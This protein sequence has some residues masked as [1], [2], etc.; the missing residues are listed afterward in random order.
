[1]LGFVELVENEENAKKEIAYFNFDG[2]NPR[3]EIAYVDF[4]TIASDLPEELLSVTELAYLASRSSAPQQVHISTTPGADESGGSTW[5][6]PHHVRA[7]Q[8]EA[9]SRPKSSATRRVPLWVRLKN[10]PM[11]RPTLRVEE[12]QPT[13]PQDPVAFWQLETMT[14]AGHNDESQ[15]PPLPVQVLTHE[16]LHGAEQSIFAPLRSPP[17]AAWSRLWPK[18]QDMLQSRVPSR[19]PD[20]DKWVANVAQCE[21]LTRIPPKLRR[22]WPEKI[23]IWLD[24]SAR[25]VPFWSDQV[26]VYA[27]LYRL[28]SREGIDSRVLDTYAQTMSLQQ[29]GD[30]LADARVDVDAPLLVLGDLGIFGPNAVRA[31]WLSTGKQLLRAGV[32]LS[33]LV[34]S[35][36]ARWSPFMVS[37]W[38]AVP[39]EQGRQRGAI[40]LRPDAKKWTE[41]TEQLLKL[42]SPAAYLQPEM[43]RVIRLLLPPGM[44][45]A[46]T[47]ADVWN[48]VDV[49]IADHAGLILY[50]DRAAKWR[51]KFATDTAVALKEGVG[52]VLR[53]WHKRL[54]QELLRVETLAWYATEPDVPPPGDLDDAVA[55][56]TRLD[57][58]LRSPVN[59]PI[60]ATAVKRYCRALLAQ[61]PES[62][63][64]EL[65]ALK[66]IRA[67]LSPS[68]ELNR[69]DS[70]SPGATLG[71]GQKVQH[72][73]VRQIGR[74]LEFSLSDRGTAWPSHIK[75][76]GSP[77]AWLMA[78]NPSIE[79]THP[80]TKTTK[81][82][83]YDGLS[84]PIVHDEPLQLQTD[85]CTAT[86][87]PWYRESWVTA[88]GHDRFGLW[89]DAKI[90]DVV[91]RFRWIPPGRYLMGLAN[92]EQGRNQDTE[93]YQPWVSWTEGRWMADT[94]VTQSLWKAVTGKN[95]SYFQSKER[96][97]A[98]RPVES[99]GWDECVA[100]AEKVGA[101]LPSEAEW[102]Y[103]CRAGTTTATW[104][105]DPSILSSY[106]APLLDTIAWY[107]GNCGVGFDLEVFY[108]T[109]SWPDKQHDFAKGGTNP[110]RRKEP[111]LF[112][113]Y[114]M[115]GNVHEWCL[116]ECH[117][118]DS[119][120]ANRSA[121]NHGRHRIVRGGSWMN[122]AGDVRASFRGNFDPSNG[123]GYV[124][125]RIVRDKSHF[126][127]EMSKHS[128]SASSAHFPP[129]FA[130]AWE[131]DEWG[132]V[133]TFAVAHVEHR[134]RWITPGAF[135]MGSPSTEA[136]RKDQETLHR[137]ELTRGYWLG[138]TPV[139]QA[140]WRAVMGTNP[141]EFSDDPRRPVE[142]ISWDDCQLFV[143][144]L[145]E[146]VKGLNARLPT[147]AEW[148]YACRAGSTTATWAGELDIQG[149]EATQLDSIA[150][151][152]ANSKNM[153]HPV[154]QKAANPWGLYDMLGNVYEWCSDWEGPYG[155]QAIHDP[156]GPATGDR[157][158]FRGGGWF[159]R[160]RAVRA[161]HR[162]WEASTYRIN[163][164][165]F[166]L[167]LD[168]ST[169]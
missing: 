102:E 55:F 78:D 66:N 70:N 23:T 122:A 68:N 71:Q 145:N 157:R 26:E 65:P 58:S 21:L 25:L 60:V 13:E 153:T 109:T 82:E 152:S 100:W 142:N 126:G 72:W 32:R 106:N 18:L 69:I 39:W 12:P 87:S 48:H 51:E 125:M 49:R 161:A 1:M 166:R 120:V 128:Q 5:E 90:H 168:S 95:P 98:D 146:R 10:M 121:N 43:L 22:V 138:E 96:S 123:Y 114:D 124:G 104:A 57:G 20:V 37:V 6:I 3:I 9:Q 4:N 40:A 30:F 137:V 61:V 47:E 80:K 64:K 130:I 33:A 165:G 101:R 16:D 148:E 63:D 141:S 52:N 156:Q 56:V 88:A 164:V 79:I 8:P 76:P 28:C 116:D 36:A 53:Q 129:A 2:M 163:R 44:A 110:V 35:C 133:A 42:V 54:P 94:P 108:E 14:F 127:E 38:N 158:I 46:S 107:G 86:I 99:V 91:V 50:A 159:S 113:L 139:T 132:L 74:Q 29:R 119:T 73:A 150:W 160:A 143:Q 85:C 84:I 45:D 89:A 67:T 31:A 11:P 105:G 93:W 131:K 169:Q 75:G 155:I 19:E 15:D 147:E 149:D 136:G 34:P 118:Q 117:S 162:D 111:N 17:L 115:L 112:G 7:A 83:L 154:A 97:T 62:L 77:I 134:V 140:L 59:S 41:R 144:T 151:Y 135:A 81:H 24:A 103:A 27:Q 92:A 167:A